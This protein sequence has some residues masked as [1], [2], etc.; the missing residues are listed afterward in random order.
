MIEQFRNLKS[1][2]PDNQQLALKLNEVICA[3]EA[4]EAGQ[5]DA[6]QLKQAITELEWTLKYLPR[7]C[8]HKRS[9]CVRKRGNGS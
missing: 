1:D 2:I 5:P 4:K 8:T 6:Q 9:S 3:L 7:G